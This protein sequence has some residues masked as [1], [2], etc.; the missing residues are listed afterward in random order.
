M[1]LARDTGFAGVG[2][3]ELG[4]RLVFLMAGC[5]YIG[6]ALKDLVSAPRPTGLKGKGGGDFRPKLIT[7]N[8]EAATY[9]LVCSQPHRLLCPTSLRHRGV[10]STRPYLT[11]GRPLP[12]SM[13]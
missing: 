2:V 11:G 8:A 4:W 13:H 7:S 9:A 12:I 10:F 5:L 1:K 6:N 3:P